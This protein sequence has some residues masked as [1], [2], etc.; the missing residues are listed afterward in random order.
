MLALGPTVPPTIDYHPDPAPTCAQR[1]GRAGRA[2]TR[3]RS[4][5]CLRFA[6]GKM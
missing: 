3:L 5:G 6:Y 4:R 2:A 1:S